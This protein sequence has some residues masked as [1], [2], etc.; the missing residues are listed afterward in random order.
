MITIFQ[1]KF[2]P[3]L[4]EAPPVAHEPADLA[5]GPGGGPGFLPWPLPGEGHDRADERVDPRERGDVLGVV[6]VPALALAEVLAKL[7][8]L[9]AKIREIIDGLRVLASPACPDDHRHQKQQD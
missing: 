3:E 1:A 7:H 5:L 8:E 6:L 4:D 2:I 9:G